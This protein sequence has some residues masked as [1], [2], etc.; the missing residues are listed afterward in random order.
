MGEGRTAVA[1]HGIAWPTAFLKSVAAE[2]PPAGPAGGMLIDRLPDGDLAP[3]DAPA[4]LRVPSGALV[5]DGWIA[6]PISETTPLRG[7]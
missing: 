6:H 3:T 1:A 5:T 4:D 2:L 7:I